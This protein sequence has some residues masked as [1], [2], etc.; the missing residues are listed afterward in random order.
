MLVAHCICGPEVEVHDVPD[1]GEAGHALLAPRQHGAQDLVRAPVV[2]CQR[3][4]RHGE[5]AARHPAP[6]QLI[7]HGGQVPETGHLASLLVLEF[8]HLDV[9]RHLTLSFQ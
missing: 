2:S 1:D 4:H 5:V 8:F 3:E 6:P 9:E 7:R